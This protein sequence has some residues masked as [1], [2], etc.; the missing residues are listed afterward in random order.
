LSLTTQERKIKEKLIIFLL[1]LSLLLTPWT[2]LVFAY[3]ARITH[4]QLRYTVRF[5]FLA[6]CTIVTPVT[7][8]SKVATKRAK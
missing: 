7:G 6:A 1:S 3:Q 8:K 2:A 5:L 4:T